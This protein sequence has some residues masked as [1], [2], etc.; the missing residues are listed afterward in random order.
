MSSEVKI[1]VVNV[2]KEKD[3][4][5]ICGM[6]NF[7]VYTCDNI[8][9]ELLA[10]VPG[11]KCGVAM[12]EAAPRL[13]RV[14]ANDERLKELAAKNALAIGASHAYVIL[15][16]EAFPI[17]VLNALKNVPGICNVIVATANPVQLI[18]A[19]TPLGRAI[20]GAVDGNSVTNI[21]NEEQ[22]KERR[23]LV[24]KLGY[25]LG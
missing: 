3:D 14:N 19:E 15:M 22:R 4:Q 6:A 13:V 25:I 7:T 12:N 20:L 11:I 5:F 24:R 17:N 1:I 10:A 18:I 2:E 23:E 21:E 9:R 8:F 16:K